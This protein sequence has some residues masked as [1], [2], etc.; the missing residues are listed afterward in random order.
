MAETNISQSLLRVPVW[1]H[2]ILQKCYEFFCDDAGHPP[3]TMGEIFIDVFLLYLAVAIAALVGW[4]VYRYIAGEKEDNQEDD[5]K[6]YDSSPTWRSIFLSAAIKASWVVI[7][8]CAGSA[9]VSLI[10]MAGVQ[11]TFVPVYRKML[12]NFCIAAGAQLILVAII[13]TRKSRLDEEDAARYTILPAIYDVL[14][15]SLPEDFVE[16]SF[17]FLLTV[18]DAYIQG[19]KRAHLFILA[20][21]PDTDGSEYIRVILDVV[22]SQA[23][24]EMGS[25]YAM[26]TPAQ[27]NIIDQIKLRVFNY[28]SVEDP[29]ISHTIADAKTFH[30]SKR[31]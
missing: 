31:S 30:T 11:E 6:Y 19:S 9:I 12:K 15:T 4:V 20:K 26:F 21:N 13:R 1:V 17:I 8:V 22:Y 29:W 28:K 3:A 25:P 14:V 16:K 5:D 23:S 7:A 24:T 18:I 27:R 2:Y 10:I